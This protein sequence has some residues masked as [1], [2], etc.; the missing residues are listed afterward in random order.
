MRGNGK[1]PAFL[2]NTDFSAT[3]FPSTAASSKVL[4]SQAADP[5]FGEIGKGPAPCARGMAPL[6]MAGL[7]AEGFVAPQSK[8]ST[9]SFAAPRLVED[10]FASLPVPDLQSA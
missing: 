3:P 4:S 5:V 10:F 2:P 6:R 7:I 1:S 9:F 8:I